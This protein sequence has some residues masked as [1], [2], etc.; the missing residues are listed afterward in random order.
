MTREQQKLIYWL[1]N[2]YSCYLAGYEAGSKTSKYYNYLAKEQLKKL[3]LKHKN[4]KMSEFKPF[5]DLSSFIDI[6]L[7]KIQ[8]KEI[9]KNNVQSYIISNIQKIIYQFRRWVFTCIAYDDK[10]KRIRFS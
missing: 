8:D 3:F 10:R 4:I 9:T 1:I 7:D 6:E 2:D 5:S